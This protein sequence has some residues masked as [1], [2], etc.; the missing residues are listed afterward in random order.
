MGDKDDKKEAVQW[1][2]R[3]VSGSGT[4]PS[5]ARLALKRDAPHLSLNIIARK[6]TIGPVAD[7]RSPSIPRSLTSNPLFE[8]PTA[9]LD[10]GASSEKNVLHGGRLL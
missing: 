7:R 2:S 5:A 8:V 10:A 4:E 1:I 6:Q 3:C 9:R